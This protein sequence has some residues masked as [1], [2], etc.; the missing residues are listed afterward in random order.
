MIIAPDPGPWQWFVKRS[1]NVGLPTHVVKLK[2]MQQQQL[3]EQS[4]LQSLQQ[5]MAMY[6]APQ[7]SVQG[8]PADNTVNNYIIDDYVEDYLQ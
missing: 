2:Y 6:S 8:S 3:F 4:M 5:Q 7:Q 1:D